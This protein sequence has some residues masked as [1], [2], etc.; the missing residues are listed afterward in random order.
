MASYKEKFTTVGSDAEDE[1]VQVENGFVWL[2]IETSGRLVC[3]HAIDSLGSIKW[4]KF[5]DL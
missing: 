1:L 2:R 3:E 4:G 5:L